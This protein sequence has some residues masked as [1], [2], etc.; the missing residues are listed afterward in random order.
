MS[1]YPTSPLRAPWQ[2]DAVHQSAAAWAL[3]QEQGDLTEG[4]QQ[5]F[6]QWL[7]E[8]DAHADAYADAVWA[9]NATARHAGDPALLELRRSALGARASR[10]RLWSWTG[11][12]VAAAAALVT[13]MI[14]TTG[15]ERTLVPTVQPPSLAG[16][17][18]E[19][20][21]QRYRTGVGERAAIDLPDGSVATLDTDSQIRVDYSQGERAVHLIKG[22]ALFEVAHG[23]PRPFRV[24]ARGQEITAVGTIFNVR[25]EG[26]RVRIAMVQGV[27]KVRAAPRAGATAGAPRREIT[28]TAGD[29]AIAAPAAP[30]EVRPVEPRDVTAWRG[31]QIVFNDVPLAEAVAEINRYTVRPIAL[32]DA[33]VGRYRVSGVFK[34]NDPEAFAR[35]ATEVLPV[36]I[37]QAGEGPLTLRAQGD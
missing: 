25:L 34:A 13:A 17:A 35:A 1:P 36:R 6:A 9:L 30:L 11:A 32:A 19:P 5:R 29:G 21:T 27:V 15:P 24:Y 14:W 20:A 23:Q 16:A 26:E 28:L 18:G 33:A 22:Q 3:R 4:E 10:K 7:A 31:G 12:A 8:D 2:P 37:T